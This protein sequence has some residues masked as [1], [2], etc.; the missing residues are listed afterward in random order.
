VTPRPRRDKLLPAQQLAAVVRALYA[1]AEQLDWEHLPLAEHTRQY[2]RWVTDSRVGAALS[3]YMTTEQARSWIKDGPMKE[4]AR[5]RRGAGRYAQYGAPGG[6]GP[7]D[8]LLHAL[9]HDWEIVEGSVGVKPF[10]CEAVSGTDVAFVAW[11]A[12]GN[13]RHLLWAALRWAV[14]HDG[15]SVVVVTE[16][17]ARPTP[18][19]QASWHKRVGARC[20]LEV[21]HMRERLVP[22]PPSSSRESR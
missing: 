11:G 13:F 22:M 15:R 12:A 1:D 21:T 17:A 9:G 5:A 18:E 4:F 2:G 10:H 7:A 8:V 3:R 14:D 16:L 6:T 20:G 19:N